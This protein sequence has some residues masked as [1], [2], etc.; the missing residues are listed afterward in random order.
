MIPTTLPPIKVN[1]NDFLLSIKQLLTEVILYY[2]ANG[3]YT[4]KQVFM[5]LELTNFA[6]LDDFLAS[7]PKIKEAKPNLEHLLGF[8]LIVPFD[9]D[10]SC[11]QDVILA[12]LIRSE[13][14]SDTIVKQNRLNDFLRWTVLDKNFFWSG[15]IATDFEASNLINSNPSQYRITNFTEYEQKNWIQS[16]LKDNYVVSQMSFKLKIF[17][18]K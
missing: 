16:Q 8:S 1:T 13:Y 17:K 9:F 14:C 6:G 7:Y 2:R 10:F 11:K 12:V 3:D 5:G 15:E 18:I 4:Q